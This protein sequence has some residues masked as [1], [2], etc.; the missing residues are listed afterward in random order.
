MR[1]EWCQRTV[2]PVIRPIRLVKG[3][4]RPHFVC[5]ERPPAYC[6]K[7]RSTALHCAAAGGHADVLRAL[8]ELGGRCDARAK[9]GETAAHFAAS[10]GS[11]AVV[12]ALV[13][14]CALST[15]CQGLFLSG[16]DHGYA[17][18]HSVP[19][20]SRFV[21]LV[22]FLSHTERR[23]GPGVGELRRTA[24]F[25]RQPRSHSD[26]NHR[27]RATAWQATRA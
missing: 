6:Q 7:A 24:R 19:L 2:R 18:S 21:P 13:F 16:W 4:I 17:P 9:K 15:D 10:C 26:T 5:M 20:R 8:A 23:V 14:S 3:V 25:A 27:N 22:L 1:R 12:R 11:T